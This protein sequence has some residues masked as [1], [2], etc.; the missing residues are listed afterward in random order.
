[1]SFEEFLKLEESVPFFI[2][3]F[4]YLYEVST[5]RTGED[6]FFLSFLIIRLY[7]SLP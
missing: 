5:L 1:M 3:L 6:D 4:I 2:Y 7:E